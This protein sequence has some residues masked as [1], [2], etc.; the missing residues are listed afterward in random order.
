MEGEYVKL[1]LEK[2]D[3]LKASD[4]NKY[5]KNVKDALTKFVGLSRGINGYKVDYTAHV[6][7]EELKKLIEKIMDIEC[8]IDFY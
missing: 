5:R 1:S 6:S 2:Y 8:D 4:D 3:E 7:K